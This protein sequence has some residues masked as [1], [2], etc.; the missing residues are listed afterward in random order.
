MP[1][2][3]AVEDFSDLHTR[4]WV[5][6]AAEEGKQQPFA[7]ALKRAEGMKNEQV[8][9]ERS[10][11]SF[12]SPASELRLHPL[13]ATCRC[14]DC[15]CIRSCE[16]AVSGQSNFAVADAS[17]TPCSRNRLFDLQVVQ[18]VLL[19]S[20]TPMEVRRLCARKDELFRDL[21]GDAKSAMPPGTGALLQLLQKHN[22]SADLP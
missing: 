6:L 4:A 9:F 17:C 7:W 10:A 16:W 8:R 14:W 13:K 15:S 18:E 11:C 21:R 5:Q 3:Q 2:L 20:R 1:I 22:V 19:W 12:I